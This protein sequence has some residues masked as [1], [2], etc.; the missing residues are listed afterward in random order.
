[1]DY[2][3]GGELF[4]YMQRERRFSLERVCFYVA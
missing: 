4:K 3:A 1:M 2:M